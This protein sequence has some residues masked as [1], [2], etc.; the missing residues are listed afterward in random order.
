MACQSKRMSHG[1][2]ELEMPKLDQFTLR[3]PDLTEKILG[4]LDNEHLEK[5]KTV[6]RSLKMTVENQRIYWIRMIQ[7]YTKK[8]NQFEMEWNE[9]V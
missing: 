6:S 3:F 1:Q 2:E 7:N 5:F 9:A 4:Q 8:N